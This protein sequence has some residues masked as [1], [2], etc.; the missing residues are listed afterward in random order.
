M[1]TKTQISTNDHARILYAYLA[2]LS[3]TD[4]DE[5]YKTQ[6]AA[7]HASLNY[8]MSTQI[9]TQNEAMLSVQAALGRMIDH[10]KNNLSQIIGSIV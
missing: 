2:R 3:Q 5:I 1:Q 7:W 4:L 6:K 8:G 9:S 10:D